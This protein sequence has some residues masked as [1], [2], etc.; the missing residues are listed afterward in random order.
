MELYL[1]C[2]TLPCFL[3]PSPSQQVGGQSSRVFLSFHHASE[4]LDHLYFL[5][6]MSIARWDVQNHGGFVWFLHL[7]LTGQ[8]YGTLH[9]RGDQ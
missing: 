6:F 5:V 2:R 7:T 4:V 1:E 9:K 8:V 3:Y